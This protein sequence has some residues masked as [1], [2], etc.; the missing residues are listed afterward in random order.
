MFS[1]LQETE[2]F[3]CKICKK[4]YARGTSLKN[5]MRIVHKDPE[6]ENE[7]LVCTKCPKRFSTEKKLKIHEVVHLPNSLKLIHPCVYC[8]KKSFFNF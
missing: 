1:S 8:D 7:V 2:Y 3:R 6:Y 5:H 4:I